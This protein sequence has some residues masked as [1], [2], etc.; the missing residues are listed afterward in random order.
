MDK[1]VLSF[2]CDDTSPYGLAHRDFQDLFDF[3]SSEGIAGE[4]SV[5]LGY[6]SRNT[7]C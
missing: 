4:S 5:I 7:T 2:Y 6:Q 3:V 1:T